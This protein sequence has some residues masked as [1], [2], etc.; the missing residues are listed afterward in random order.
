MGYDGLSV[1][2]SIS[3]LPYC[4]VRSNNTSYL[5][6]NVLKGLKPV[7]IKIYSMPADTINLKNIISK[8]TLMVRTEDTKV[9]IENFQHG[10]VI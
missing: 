3:G 8:T 7:I 9:H 6:D 4:S 5:I 10:Y 1:P 2:N